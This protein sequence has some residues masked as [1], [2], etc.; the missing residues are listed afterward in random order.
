MNFSALERSIGVLEKSWKF[1]SERGYEPCISMC[2]EI[3]NCLSR[4]EIIICIGNKNNR[5]Q[6]KN[7]TNSLHQKSASKYTFLYKYL[8]KEISVCEAHILNSFLTSENV[9]H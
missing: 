1:V 2:M 5:K 4:K 6:C 7:V 9:A 8:K 3:L